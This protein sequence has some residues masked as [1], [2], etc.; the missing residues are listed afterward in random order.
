MDELDEVI[1]ATLMDGKPRNFNQ[2]L[3]EIDLSHNTLRLHLDY[4]VEEVLVRREKTRGGG[5]GRPIFTYSLAS[6]GRGSTSTSPSVSGDTVSLPFRRLGQI[7]RFEKGGFCK[8][9]RC[10]CNAQNCPQIDK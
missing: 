1:L 6:A 10:P 7:C 4:L 9:M 8:K 2:L 5:R 3:K